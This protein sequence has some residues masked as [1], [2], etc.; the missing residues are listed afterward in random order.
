MNKYDKLIEFMLSHD[1]IN[2]SDF[3]ISRIPEDID[4]RNKH[5]RLLDS[6]ENAK[7]Q[8][9][10]IHVSDQ[11]HE[12][13]HI[14]VNKDFGQIPNK[15]RFYLCPT[16]KNLL[17]LVVE[18]I[19][20]SFKEGQRTYVKYCQNAERLDQLIVYLEDSVDMKLKLDMLKEIKT[21]RPELFQ[22]MSQAANWVD[23]TSIPNVY[24]QA[25]P[26]INRRI[27]LETSYGN[28]CA[29][30]LD[31]TKKILEYLYGVTEKTSLISSKSDSLFASRFKNVYEEMLRRYGIF[32]HKDHNGNLFNTKVEGGENNTPLSRFEYDKI[33]G[34]LTE[35]R[36]EHIGS[37]TENKEKRWHFGQSTEEK[38]AFMQSLITKTFPDFDD[39]S[40]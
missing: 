36:N 14:I 2:Y 38:T 35:I 33:T 39:G 18:I 16:R 23:E 6:I 30:A 10:N 9:G 3:Y 15:I 12:F 17:P 8:G 1:N 20:R 5:L 29:Y 31:D 24:L 37:Q 11:D 22:E 34:V 21:D 25:N 26:Q 28:Q 27:G 7:K 13:E 32:L 19:N 40:R 4:F